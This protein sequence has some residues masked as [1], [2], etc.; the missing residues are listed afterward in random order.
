[1]RSCSGVTSFAAIARPTASRRAMPLFAEVGVKMQT[2][3]PVRRMCS[4]ARA[5]MSMDGNV[6]V[7]CVPGLP[8]RSMNCTPWPPCAPSS[9]HVAVAAAKN[10]RT[11]S[12]SSGRSNPGA[13]PAVPAGPPGPAPQPGDGGRD[14]LVVVDDEI[15]GHR[16]G[17]CRE[18]RCSF[19]RSA[20][21]SGQMAPGW[22]RARSRRRSAGNGPAPR[23]SRRRPSPCASSGRCGLQ[24]GR[25]RAAGAGRGRRRVRC[26]RGGRRA[27]S[28][29]SPRAGLR[30][31][32]FSASPPP[33]S[34]TG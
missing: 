31:G 17:R 23:R 30:P 11:S 16:G 15:A 8:V 20:H 28:S 13:K 29:R 2:D 27:R 1:M 6:L 18:H 4:T 25:R 10:C 3:S 24:G 7:V 33:A 19:V 22:G 21:G 34:R 32:R 12:A 9:R 26:R 14:D 5:T